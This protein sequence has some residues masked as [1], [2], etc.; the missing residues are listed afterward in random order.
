MYKGAIFSWKRAVCASVSEWICPPA[1]IINFSAICLIAVSK[2][3][4]DFS[5]HHLIG[6]GMAFLAA[7]CWA[8]YSV[9]NRD[10]DAPISATSYVILFSGILSLIAYEIFSDFTLINISNDDLIL[11]LL[12]ALWPVGYSLYLPKQ[13][14]TDRR[15]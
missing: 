8:F 9:K 2:A 15:E 6:Y 5:M 7:N 14:L 11:L 4:E 13:V 12:L 10:F 3:S 1:S